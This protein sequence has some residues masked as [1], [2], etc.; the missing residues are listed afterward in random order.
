MR[1]RTKK[2]VKEMQVGFFVFLG[3]LVVAA[4]SFRITETPIFY[5]GT[6]IIAYLDDATGLFKKSKVKMAGIDVGLVTDIELEQGKAKITLTIQEGMSIP[7]NAKVIPRPLG[8]LGD[9]YLEIILPDPADSSTERAPD[10]E[11]DTIV[12]EEEED[13]L[14]AVWSLIVPGVS[15]QSSSGKLQSG[16]VIQTKNTSATVDDLARELADVSADLK[17]ISSTL[18]GMVEGKDMQTPLGRTLV[19]TESLTENLDVVVRENRKDMRQIIKSLAR[20]SRSL[21]EIANEDK[22]DGLGKDIQTL[23]QATAKLSRSI[24]HIESILKKVDEGQGTLGKLVN[25]PGIVS[26]FNRALVTVNAALDRAERTQIYVEAIPEFSITA[27]ETKTYVGL[28][29][30]P[31]DNTAYIAQIVADPE[32]STTTKITSSTTDGVTTTT[33]EEET[34]PSGL[35]FSLQYNKKFW[36]TGFRVGLFEDKGGLAVDQYL[37]KDKLI[38]TSELFNF[39]GTPNLKLRASYK[40]LEV[41]MVSAG[42]EQTLSDSRFAFVGV[43]LSFSDEDLRTVLLLPGVP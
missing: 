30:A 29:L 12:L 7:G 27:Q 38:L 10:S 16:D 32:G 8:I 18:R 42:M 1:E 20:L 22:Q 23:A 36:N 11:K 14:S 19:N 33:R 37:L 35:K 4:F 15:A 17:V 24:V 43:G 39:S 2:G 34:N 26:E 25:D 41:F 13:V 21:E 31:R 3:L 5:Q 40:F 9:K 28:R 6:E